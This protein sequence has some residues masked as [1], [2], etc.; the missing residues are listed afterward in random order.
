MPSVSAVPLPAMSSRSAS[1]SPARQRTTCSTGAEYFFFQFAG[2]V[3]FDNDGRDKGAA[4]R[5][6]RIEPEAQGTARLH[7]G[8]P[9]VE[10]VF[11]LGVDHRADLDRRVAR[12]AQRQLARRAGDH[13]EH[14]VGNILLHAEQTQRRA[15]LTGGAEGRG[16]D[17]V[18]HLLGQRGGV[19]DHGVDAAGLSDQRRDRPLPGGE[20]AVDEAGDPRVEPV[21]ATP[22][23]C[24]VAV[25]MAPI[26]PSPGT[27]CS[28][29]AGTPAAC[30][31]FTAS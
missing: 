2:A 21:K 31:S 18:G 20:R 22:A 3:E 26:A 29:L 24:G 23:T 28:A 7:A 10:F 27:K 25:S 11:G 30:M 12:I 13:V 15:A 17:V 8:D 6:S 5:R 9:A 14:A 1:S 16:D 4:G 19:D